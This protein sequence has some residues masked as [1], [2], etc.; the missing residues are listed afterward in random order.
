VAKSGR[1]CSLVTDAV[2]TSPSQT[3]HI[4]V[5]CL[6]PFCGWAG[7]TEG[8][9]ACRSR[10]NVRV[11]NAKASAFE[12]QTGRKKNPCK[13]SRTHKHLYAPV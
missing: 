1:S 12:E 4:F 11:A 7:P 9:A 13:I 6:R 10:T 8:T 3:C 5:G 2:T